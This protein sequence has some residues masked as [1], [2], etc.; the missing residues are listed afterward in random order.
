MVVPIADAYYMAKNPQ[1]VWKESEVMKKTAVQMKN[2]FQTFH[3]SGITL[4][5]SKMNIYRLLPTWIIKIGLTLV[6]KSNIVR[7]LCISIQ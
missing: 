3:K 4:S 6:F 1:K 7:C 5:P 2:N